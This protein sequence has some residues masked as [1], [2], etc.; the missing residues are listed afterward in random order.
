MKIVVLGL[1]ITSTWG[2]GHATTYRSLIRALAA[3]KHEVL[4]LERD[5]EWYAIQRDMAEPSFCRLG[6]YSTLADLKC[7]FEA[8][9]RSADLV[10]VGSYVAEGVGLFAQRT[11]FR[12]RRV[13]NR[14][15]QRSLGR[16]RE[17][18]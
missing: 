3:R 5:V 6:L 18:L 9:V 12:S 10:I 15:D 4:F 7:R 2:N 17:F 16:R 13:W 1:S 8:D 11:P 14:N